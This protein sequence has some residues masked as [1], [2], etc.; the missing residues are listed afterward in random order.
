VYY[1]IAF[2]GF[3]SS[4]LGLTPS[5]FA[6]WFVHLSCKLGCNWDFFS[7]RVVTEIFQLQVWLQLEKT[8]L[9]R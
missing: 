3:A 7:Y 2:N 6:S 1:K 8:P 5:D 4:H 9:D